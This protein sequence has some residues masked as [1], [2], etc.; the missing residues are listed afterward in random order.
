M[1][2][3][4]GRHLH[5]AH[6]LPECRMCEEPTRRAVWDDTGGF[7]SACNAGIRKAAQLLPTPHPEGR[8]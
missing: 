4:K 8:S 5:I 7:C 3:A 6:P 1:T 2:R